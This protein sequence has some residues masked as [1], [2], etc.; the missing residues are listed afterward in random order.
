MVPFDRDRDF[1]GRADIIG[2]ID[3]RFQAN[4]RRIALAGIGGIG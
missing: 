2:E 4:R 3:R 1:V